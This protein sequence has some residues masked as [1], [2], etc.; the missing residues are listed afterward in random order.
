MHL[1]MEY[2]YNF[3]KREFNNQVYCIYTMSFLFFLKIQAIKLSIYIMY[4]FYS[5]SL[6][7]HNCMLF[8]YFIVNGYIVF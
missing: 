8:F 6:S 4:F 5:E 3:T 7:S 2:K 1:N